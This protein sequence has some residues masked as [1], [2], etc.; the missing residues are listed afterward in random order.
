MNLKSIFL[1]IFIRNF[2]H[3]PFNILNPLPQKIRVWSLNCPPDYVALGY[4]TTVAPA[5]PEKGAIYCVRSYFVELGNVIGREQPVGQVW[6]AVWDSTGFK[7][8][9]M[10]R[11]YEQKNSSNADHLSPE[12]FAAVGQTAAG[13]NQ[14]NPAYYLQKIH[15]DS[16]DEVPVMKQWIKER[17]CSVLDAWYE[18][19]WSTKMS[20]LICMF[21]IFISKRFRN[22]KALKT[23]FKKSVK[24]IL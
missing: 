21:S 5:F 14:P 15:V 7:S 23:S 22:S 16:Y 3:P 20:F 2:C 17:L 18:N 19:F 1:W 11:F 9:Q 13:W 6:A 12:G 4:V 24:K 8:N 10:T